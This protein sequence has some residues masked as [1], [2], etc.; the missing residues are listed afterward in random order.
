MKKLFLCML[1]FVSLH[2]LFCQDANL[3]KEINEQVWR[4]F[5]KT[6]NAYDTEGFMAIHTKDVIR[7]SRDGKNIWIGEEY[8]ESMRQNQEQSLKSNLKRD[9]SFTFLERIA[10]P[11]VAFEVGFYKVS[12]QREGEE[13]RSFY[14]KFHVILKKVDGQWKLDIDSDTSNKGQIA[15]SDFQSGKKMEEWE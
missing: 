5:I 9:I 8:H 13:A 6:Y 12:I 14:G 11:E 15:E 10:R 2:P 4:P 7:I 3:Q 1:S